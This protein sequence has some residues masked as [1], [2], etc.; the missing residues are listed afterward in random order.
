MHGAGAARAPR[1]RPAGH[2]AQRRL[3]LHRRAHDLLGP[4]S[5]RRRRAP[6]PAGGEAGFEVEG[7]RRAVPGAT[8]H[9]AALRPGRNPRPQLAG[10][11]GA[12]AG[13][14]KRHVAQLWPKVTFPL[15]HSPR[16]TFRQ[17]PA[18][19]RS[20]R[21]W[22]PEADR[23]AVRERGAQMRRPGT[24]PAL[25]VAA[26]GLLALGD[27]GGGPRPPAHRRSA[28]RHRPRAVGPV[29]R[30]EAGP[31]EHF[32]APVRQA[33]LPRPRHLG[34]LARGYPA[35]QRPQDGPTAGRWTITEQIATPFGTTRYRRLPHWTLDGW[36]G[37]KNFAQMDRAQPRPGTWWPGQKVTFLPRTPTT[38]E[39]TGPGSPATDR[40]PAAVPRW[41]PVRGWAR[42][43]GITARLGRRSGGEFRRHRFQARPGHLQGHRDDP[44]RVS[45]GLFHVAARN[46]TA[47]V[48]VHVVK[49]GDGV[50][51]RPRQGP[52]RGVRRCPRLPE[53]SHG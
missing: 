41:R 34:R 52:G 6:V 18:A 31:G 30:L 32:R 45:P 47:T 51:T 22:T 25:P 13:P 26:A 48:T 29:L 53:G 49:A 19:L 24:R 46:A 37:L 39:R 20:V 15:L 9:R 8:A 10:R 4:A 1:R 3:R 2:G 11:S 7:G 40:F 14:R 12:A 44:P 43:G 42:C 23:T 33:G 16:R 38:P 5:R 28:P 50:G 35:A 27:R 17:R 36:N 21:R